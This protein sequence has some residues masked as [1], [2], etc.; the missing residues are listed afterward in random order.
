MRQAG[1]QSAAAAVI[2]RTQPLVVKIF[3]FEPQNFVNRRSVQRFSPPL[4]N[5]KILPSK[6]TQP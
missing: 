6:F 4:L 5:G 1:S 3:G 2:I